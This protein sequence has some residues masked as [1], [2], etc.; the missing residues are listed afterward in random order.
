MDVRLFHRG[1]A[2]QPAIPFLPFKDNP[3]RKQRTHSRSFPD[4]E[5]GRS[6]TRTKH[7][8]LAASPAGFGQ[9]GSWHRPSIPEHFR[10]FSESPNRGNAL[11]VCFHAIPNA[12]PLRTLLELP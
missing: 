7:S 11:S 8:R 2:L 4:R 1:F 12:K 3:E 5:P 6:V 9:R 10:F